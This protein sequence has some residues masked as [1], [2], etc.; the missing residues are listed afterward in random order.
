MKMFSECSGDCLICGSSGGGC[1]AGHG[2]DDFYLASEE[3]LRTI[4]RIKRAGGNPENRE[5]SKLEL[6]YVQRTLEQSYGKK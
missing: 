2:D 3:K 5:L 1:L 6:E 4:L